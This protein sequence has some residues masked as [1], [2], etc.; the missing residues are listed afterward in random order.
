MYL[1]TVGR[2]GYVTFATTP[3][4]RAAIGLTEDGIVR[5]FAAGDAPGQWR[6]LREWR[7][8]A[9]SHTDLVVALGGIEEPE[10]AEDL[11]AS[12]PAATLG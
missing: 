6:T 11:L 7:S 8:A 4:G 12:L 3:R 2:P 10:S 9:H 5:L 1:V